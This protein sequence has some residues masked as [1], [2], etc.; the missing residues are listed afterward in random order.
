MTE[1]T[2]H[3]GP[4]PFEVLSMKTTFTDLWRPSGTIGRG[5]YALI[6][7]LG[8]ALK[9][10]ID[11]QVAGYGFHRPWTLFNYWVPLRDVVR[12][13]ELSHDQAVFL[14]TMVVLSL[15]FIWLGVAL[16][17]KRLR[18]AGLSTQLVALF[19]LPFLNLLFFL[20][21]CLA[22]ERDPAKGNA[23]NKKIPSQPGTLQRIFP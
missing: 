17:M 13:T 10:N 1:V 22:P 9:H 21:L 18:S 12:I 15:P 2:E 3:P 11:R 14:G 16:T 6:G 7:L 4:L 20:I 8:F 23:D 5:T 19:F